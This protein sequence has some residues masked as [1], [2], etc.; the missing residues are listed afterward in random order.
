ML[1]RTTNRSSLIWVCPVCQRL[2]CQATGVRNFRTF[3]ALAK[4]I[5]Q[6]AFSLRM[7]P[8]DLDP[9]CFQCM[10]SNFEKV[11]QATVALSSRS[12][13]N[14]LSYLYNLIASIKVM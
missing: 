3:T 13:L 1:V 9:H 5:G 2:F 8:V 4:G 10:V 14:E 12:L 6:L 11:G 7:K